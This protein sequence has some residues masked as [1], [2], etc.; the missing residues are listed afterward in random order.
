MTINELIHRAHSDA[1]ANG[2]WDQPR[3][4]GEL[5]MLIVSECGEALEAHRRGMVSSLETENARSPWISPKEY[6]ALIISGGSSL[7]PDGKLFARP[8]EGF[9]LFLKD[10]FAFELADIVIRIADLCGG[11][12]DELPGSVIDSDSAVDNVGESLMHVVEVLAMAR[13][14][15]R[16]GLFAERN[17]WLHT[18]IGHASGIAEAHNIDLLRHIELKL[19]YN[20]TRGHKHG[21]QY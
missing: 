12:G 10:C 9:D 16:K 21:K 11:L 3:N 5:L 7:S 15:H 13:I 17:S 6:D 20:K 14:D 1:K 2:W 18:A 4:T 8:R 19:A